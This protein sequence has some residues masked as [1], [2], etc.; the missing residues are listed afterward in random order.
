MATMEDAVSWTIVKPAGKLLA[1]S[2][3]ANKSLNLTVVPA[4]E[5]PGGYVKE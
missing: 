5:D 4:W 3:K 2:G 1:L